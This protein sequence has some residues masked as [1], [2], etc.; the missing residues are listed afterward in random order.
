[1]AKKGGNQIG[2][3]AFLIGVVIAVLIGL[4]GNLGTGALMQVILLVLGLVIGALNINAK[5]SKDFLIAATILVIVSNFGAS[6]FIAIPKLASTLSALLM[7]FVPA[8]V[9]VAVRNI[10]ELA[11]Q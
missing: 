3:W 1:M 9:V 5:E 11:K 4:F 8:A 7:L 2:S 10:A 6:A